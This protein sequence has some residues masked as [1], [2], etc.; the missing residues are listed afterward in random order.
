MYETQQPIV[1]RSGQFAARRP[2]VFTPWAQRRAAQ[3]GRDEAAGC[4]SEAS[5]G[6]ARPGE[7]HREP[8]RS[9]GARQGALLLVTYLGQAR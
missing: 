9:I 7:Q 1:G 5:S 6:C 8:M 2:A 3:H 4:L